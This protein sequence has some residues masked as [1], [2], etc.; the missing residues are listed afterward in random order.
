MAGSEVRVQLILRH[1][2]RTHH[3]RAKRCPLYDGSLGR[4]RQQSMSEAGTNVWSG[5]AS[6]EGMVKI[7]SAVLH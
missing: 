3:A 2:V 4:V 6:Q 7:E 1:A 5:R